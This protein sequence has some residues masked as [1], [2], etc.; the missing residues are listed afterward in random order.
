MYKAAGVITD[1]E[2]RDFQVGVSET[3]R[4]ETSS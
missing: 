3:G 4:G 2:G 1:E